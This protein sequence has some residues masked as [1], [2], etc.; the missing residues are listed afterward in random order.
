MNLTTGTRDLRLI[1]QA[2]SHPQWKMP[3]G[4]YENLPDMLAEV[5]F[6]KVKE[7]GEDGNAVE[8]YAYNSRK[9]SIAARILTHMHQ[10]NI[11]AAPPVQDHN[12]HVSGD[13]HATIEQMQKADLTDEDLEK[14][15]ASASVLDRLKSMQTNDEN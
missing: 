2:V 13:I 8:R 7:T 1:E 11:N 3:E 10:Q 9:R 4:L 14:L 6:S 15:A 5:A 12:I